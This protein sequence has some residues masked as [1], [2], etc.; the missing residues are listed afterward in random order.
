MQAKRV[1]VFIVSDQPLVR[2]GLRSLIEKERKFVICGQASDCSKALPQITRSRAQL[3][4]VIKDFIGGA[5]MEAWEQIQVQQPPVSVVFVSMINDAANAAFALRAGVRGFLTK[6]T[7]GQIVEA[8][9]RVSAGQ[10]FV[11]GGGSADI[12]KTDSLVRAA[13]LLS[14]REVEVFSLVVQ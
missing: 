8:L 10:I 12:S 13:E 1:R 6:S 11:A 3:A 4:I 5:A 7:S 14:E 2:E 9:K